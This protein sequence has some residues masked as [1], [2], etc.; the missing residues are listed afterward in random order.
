MVFGELTVYV[1]KRNTKK[2]RGKKETDFSEYLC[3]TTAPVCFIALVH[4][5]VL[6][7]PSL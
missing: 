4:K 2:K 6:K 7:I 1:R 3:L 5:N